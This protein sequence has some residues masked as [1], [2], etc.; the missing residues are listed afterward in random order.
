M[1]IGRHSEPNRIDYRPRPLI[2]P[3]S[4][5]V[6]SR[7]PNIG[8]TLLGYGPGVLD[9]SETEERQVA[10]RVTLT[11]TPV[12]E[13]TT[14]ELDEES[15]RA[16]LRRAR[17]GAVSVGDQWAEFVSTGCGTTQDVTLRVS[18]VEGGSAVGPTTEFVFR[19]D[20]R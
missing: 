20:E 6:R 11:Y 8:D 7:A 5:G 1:G 4:P 19:P 15:Y 10:R 16:Y 13:R 3:R 12:G 2:R 9:M 18:S 14:A 17:R